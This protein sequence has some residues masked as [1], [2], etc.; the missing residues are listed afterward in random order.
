M[1]DIDLIYAF[2]S[3]GVIMWPLALTALAVL[4]LV[5]RAS[6]ALYVVGDVSRRVRGWLDG[7]LFWGA[8]AIALGA[9]GTF[10]GISQAASVISAG[11][12]APTSLVWSAISVSL[13][14]LIFGLGIFVLAGL[15]WFPLWRRYGQLAAAGEL[16]EMGA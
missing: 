1:A 8:M 2:R 11:G 3:G 5:L 12:G 13:T 15:A 9:L 7:L 4:T 16:N 14:T 6:H 10:G